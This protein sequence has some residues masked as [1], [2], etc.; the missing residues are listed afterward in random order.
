MIK[1]YLYDENEG[2]RILNKTGNNSFEVNEYETFRISI[3][4]LLF[5]VQSSFNINHES[6]M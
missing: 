6:N 2:K 3:T 1:Q 4:L 5:N